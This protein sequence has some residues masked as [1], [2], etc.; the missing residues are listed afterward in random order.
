FA[1]IAV[2]ELASISERRTDRMLDPARSEGLPPFLATNP[3]VESGYM[4]TQ[5]V[6]AALVAE[7]RVLA[8][9]ASVDSVPTSG[10]QEDHV[11]MGWGAAKK[12]LTVIENVRRVIAIEILCAVEAI[13]H[14]APLAPAAGTGR[15]IG[16]VR[17]KAPALE[18]D[19]SHSADIEAVARMI[20]TGE[21]ASLI[22]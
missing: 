8:H 3:G 12:L 5:Y 20:E 9:P 2:S 10:G 1:A 16:A 6:Q 15:L 21:I 7:N 17:E 13:G 4:I 18:G 22:Q 11:S 14:R 19:R